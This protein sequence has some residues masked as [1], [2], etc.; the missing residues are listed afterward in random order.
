MKHKKGIFS[1][2]VGLITGG[3]A[4]WFQPYNETKVFGVSMWLIMG[5]GA[6]LAS[7]LL[8][9]FL[10]EKTQKIALF[11]SL[12]VLL[13]VLARIFY[14]TVFWDSTSHNLAPFEILFVLAVTAPCSFIG[15]YLGFLMKRLLK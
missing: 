12:G 3:L 13:A 8:M 9:M 2:L 4:Y 1:A 10:T 6:F 14:D 5:L 15:A 11:V 7:L